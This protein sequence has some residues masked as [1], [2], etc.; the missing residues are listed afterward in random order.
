EIVFR[1]AELL[2][3]LES[4]S[5]VRVA[6]VGDLIADI[7]VTART[8]RISR[9]APVLVLRHQHEELMPG[10]AGNVIMNMVRLGARP[11]VVGWVGDDAPGRGLRAA[12]G[13]WDLDC[14]ALVTEPAR[15]TPTKT[16]ILA[17]DV[18]V[19]PRQ[20][21]RLDRGGE[22]ALSPSVRTALLATVTQLLRQPHSSLVIS[23][24]G[25][26]T[27][28]PDVLAAIRQRP[29]EGPRVLVD[30]RFSLDDFHGVD[31]VLPNEPEARALVGHSI[32]ER[33]LAETAEEMFRRIGAEHVILTLGNQGLSVFERDR[34]L[35][36]LAVSG[37]DEV[38]DTTGAGDTVTA[39]VTL[40]MG[41]AAAPQQAAF[42]ANLAAGIT[43]SRPRNECASLAD[44]RRAVD[45]LE[46]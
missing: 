40:A 34:V 25:A 7:Y 44:L 28:D 20:V 6:V 38:V 39:V 31:V 37:S 11:K 12:F 45:A 3:V 13:A 5:D 24:Y 41:A 1:K 42:L 14:A 15:P 36:H 22:E 33:P 8:E 16:R 9:E 30:S 46:A 27:I 35:C 10:G 43:V 2:S 21:V 29:M 17:G 26:Q 32:G 19:M 18:N 4:F 23:D